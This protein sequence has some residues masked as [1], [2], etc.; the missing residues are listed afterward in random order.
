MLSHRARRILIAVVGDYIARGEP[1]ASKHLSARADI[2]L[3]P[4]SI[5][6]VLAELEANGYLTKPHASAGRVPTE[7]G[8]RSFVEATASST[9][10]TPEVVEAVGELE[11][12]YATAAPGFDAL[13]RHTVRVLA[14]LTGS[15]SVVRPPRAE[16]WVLRE[17]RF[18]WLRPRE[19]LAVIVSSSGSVQNRTMRLDDALSLAELERV[20]NLLHERI[21][22]R[23]LSE[24]HAALARE[25]DAGRA[26]MNS[27]ARRALALGQ[28]ALAA[29]APDEE[30]LVEGAAQLIER[31]EFATV[32]RTRHLVRTLEDQALL[33]DLLD[34]TLQSPG[35]QVIIGSPE[36]EIGSDLSLVAATFGSGA[37][38]VI[39]S[40]RMDYSQIVP[41]VRYTARRL[42]RLV[43][44][45]GT[46]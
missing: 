29:A 1:V 28:E 14:E 23:T 13:L 43:R 22:G 2:D 27:F 4:A 7:K 10:R 8:Y 39:G 19:V 17:L 34:R 26:Q 16:N 42:A 3:S 38:G 46:N 31:P 35:I 30:V 37:V 9:E 5:R 32:D 20:N 11:R 12:R 21:D 44:E 41:L 45:G 36:H 15:A 24:V 18:I 6:A 40:T 25:L 33:L